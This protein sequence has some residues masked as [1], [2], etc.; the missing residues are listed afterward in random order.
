MKMKNN[1]RSAF[2]LAVVAALSLSAM[3]QVDSPN[4][5]TS[6]FEVNGLKVIVK[7]RPGAPTVSAGL[8][9][10]GG[11]AELTPKTAGLENL[12]LLAATEGG[13]KFPRELLRKELARLGSTLGAAAIRDYS[14]ISLSST[15]EGFGRTWELFTDATLA[16]A[17]DPDDLEIVRGRMITALR[18]VSISPDSALGVFEEQVVYAGHPYAI[19]PSGTVE[20]VSGFSVADLKEHHAKMMNTSRLL[21][22]VV[23]DVDAEEM[24]LKVTASFGRLPRGNFK[25]APV[26]PVAFTKASV[27]VQQRDIET[28]YV[29]GVFSAPSV[30]DPD[31]HAM[32]VAMAILQGRVYQEVRIKRNL[33]YAPNAEMGDASA[34]T[35]NIYVTSTDANQAV[36]VMLDEIEAMRKEGVSD[37]EFIGIPGY[38]LTTYF[39]KQETNAAQVGELARYE[40]TGGGWRNAG[41]FIRKVNAVTPAD[42]KR[43]AQKYMR[44]IRFVVVGRPGDIKRDVFLRL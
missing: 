7:K 38:F 5:T 27:D 2:M 25:P 8:F 9:V 30:A 31:Y 33:S 36:A 28:N 42:V 26:A 13:K 10:R 6:E 24:R 12:T 14:V 37:D 20:T 19:D 41:D 29:R 40:L 23:G 11:V 43:V 17:F 22:V 3:G 34:N 35:A 44:N 16:P 4:R 15:R 39:V 21:L 18:N 1:L 32:Q